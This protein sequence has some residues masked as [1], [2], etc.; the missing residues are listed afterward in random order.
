MYNRETPWMVSP[1]TP[2]YHPLTLSPHPPPP[3]QTHPHPNPPHPPT[4]PPHTRARKRTI[5][6]LVAR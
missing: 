1:P 6:A 2:T 4:H 5:Y 3:T